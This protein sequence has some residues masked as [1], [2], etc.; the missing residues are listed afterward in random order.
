MKVLLVMLNERKRTVIPPNLAILIAILKQNKIKT[1][2]FDTSFYI[3]NERLNEED[4]MEDAGIFKETDYSKIG[5]KTKSGLNKDFLKTVKGFEPDLIGLGV[6]SFTFKSAV[7]FCRLVKQRFR[8]IKTIVGGIHVSLDYEN[9]FREKSIDFFCVGEGEQA[10][11]ELCKKMEN[12]E[13]LTNI[14]NIW[15]NQNGKLI[16]TGLRQ[17]IN[18]DSLPIPDWEEFAKYHQYSPWRGKLLRMALAEFSRV[19]PFSCAYCGNKIMVELYAKHGIKLVPRYKSPKKFV[20]ELKFL[21]QKY[22]LEMIAILDGTFLV[23]PDLVLEELSRHYKKEINLP[24]YIT[25][26]ASTITLKRA[27]LL[28]KMGCICINMGIENGDFEYRKKYFNRPWTDEAL[29]KGF[30]I[31]KSVGI[32]ARAYNIIGAPFETRETIMK[33]IALNRKIKPDSSSLAIFIP[34]PGCKLRELC[35]KKGLF[36]KNE[37]IKGD[38][39]VPVIKSK[40]LTNDEIIGLFKTFMIYLKVPKKLFPIVRL[41]EEQNKFS[42]RLRKILKK[43]YLD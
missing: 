19:C 11:L 3:E 13:P 40:T 1:K 28:K 34:F 16:Q 33:T 26:T 37:L 43:I 22:A 12:K 29:K 7:K 14:K 41:A 17:P 23:F 25:T 42:N 27:K 36:G 8:N 31:I 4:T 2:L 32:E 6:D 18:L 30:D 24:F 10:L 9:I 38:G 15:Y 35:I 20:E 39:T 5:V 21:K